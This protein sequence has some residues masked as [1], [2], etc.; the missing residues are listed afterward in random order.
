MT[1]EDF[2]QFPL[3]SHLGFDIRQSVPGE[4]VAVL[5][6]DER[7]LNPNGVVHGAVLFALTDTAMGAAT[8]SQLDEGLACASIEAHIRFLAPVLSGRVE[9]RTRVLL[10]GRRVV[11]LE[12]RVHVDG[13][14]EPVAVATGSFAVISMPAPG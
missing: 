7:H 6:V 9:A 13:A 4:A 8:M 11:H 14:D 12:S 10:L 1:D 5:V 2:G 3:R